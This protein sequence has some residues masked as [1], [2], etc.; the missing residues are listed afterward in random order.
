[1]TQR[2][3]RTPQLRPDTVK[4]KS[5]EAVIRC[6]KLTRQRC[7]SPRWARD[8]GDGQQPKGHCESDR[9]CVRRLTADDAFL[10]CFKA[11]VFFTST[12]LSSRIGTFYNSKQGL[13]ATPQE[14]LPPPQTSEQSAFKALDDLASSGKQSVM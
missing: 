13:P 1:M 6:D 3:S 2:R 12:G 8:R 4:S 9:N 10:R 7:Q 11:Y 5:G 14:N